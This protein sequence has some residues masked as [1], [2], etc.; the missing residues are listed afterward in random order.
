MALFNPFVKLLWITQWTTKIDGTVTTATTAYPKFLE[1]CISFLYSQFSE[2]HVF[3]PGVDT[4]PARPGVA[5]HELLVAEI[6]K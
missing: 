6:L 1:E 3:S 2:F 4:P 5:P